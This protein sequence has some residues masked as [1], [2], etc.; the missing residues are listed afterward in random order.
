ML[1]SLLLLVLRCVFVFVRYDGVIDAVR[2]ASVVG[3]GD[4]VLV[5]NSNVSDF[6]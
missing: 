4:S 2:V 3:D 1:L 5:P 6:E